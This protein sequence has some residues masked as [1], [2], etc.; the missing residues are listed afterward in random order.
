LIGRRK[1]SRRSPAQIRFLQ[2]EGSLQQH[3]HLGAT[4]NINVRSAG[5]KRDQAGYGKSSPNAR[6]ASGDRMASRQAAD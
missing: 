6:E 3:F 5:E 4:F 1:V 2:N